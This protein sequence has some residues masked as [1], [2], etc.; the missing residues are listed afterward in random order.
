MHSDCAEVHAEVGGAQSL[1]TSGPC[2]EWGDLILPLPP[3]PQEF[4]KLKKFILPKDT[5][6]VTTA[7]TFIMGLSNFISI[8]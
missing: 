8:L 1:E 4:W 2:Q 7:K 5:T 3:L 6:A